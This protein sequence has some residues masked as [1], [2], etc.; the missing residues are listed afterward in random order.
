MTVL[1]FWKR[2]HPLWR[3]R[4]KK[5]FRALQ[6]RVDFPVPIRAGRIRCWVMLLRDFSYVVPHRA[7]GGLSYEVLARVVERFDVGHF[8]DVGANVGSF[9][10]RALNQKPTL[11]VHLFEPDDTN[12]RLLRRTILTNRLPNVSVWPGV[13]ADSSE[14]REFL[15]DDVSGATGGI[16]D[17]RSNTTSLQSAYGLSRKVVVAS[18]T[19]DACI[20]DVDAAGRV[21]VKVD[22]EGAEVEVLSGAEEFTRRFRPLYLVETFSARNLGGLLAVGYGAYALREDGNHLLVPCELEDRCK[23]I[24]T[25]TAGR[26]CPV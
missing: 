5:W 18:T 3:L 4:Q 17:H 13:V 15:V 26:M 23:D 6:R 11:K 14:P 16:I 7:G 22:V 19:L 8:F 25:L 10:W 1:S 20:P 12:L 2:S 21:L 24:L 9:A